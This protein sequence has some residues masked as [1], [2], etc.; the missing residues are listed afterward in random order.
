VLVWGT[1][2]RGP[3]C[4]Q[5]AALGEDARRGCCREGAPNRGRKRRRGRRLPRGSKDD[6]NRSSRNEARAERERVRERR[7]RER[8]VS[9][10]LDHGCMGKEGRGFERAWGTGAVGRAPGPGWAA[11]RARAHS[12]L[13]DLA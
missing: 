6:S 7:Q 3:P 11:P 10:F 9:L 4:G 8:V 5:G 1:P 13:L 12:P 2:G